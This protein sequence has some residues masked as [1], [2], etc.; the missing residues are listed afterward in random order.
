MARFIK[1]VLT[2]ILLLGVAAGLLLWYIAP[3]EQLDLTYEEVDIELKISEVLQKRRLEVQLDWNEVN[4]LAKRELVH[5]VEAGKLPIEIEGA[6]LSFDQREMK[7]KING[8][9]KGIS[10]EGTTTFIPAIEGKKIRL[11]H[12]STAIK[13][14]PIPQ[15][16][17]QLAPL[18]IAVDEYVP[19]PAQV[20]DIKLQAEGVVISLSIAGLKLR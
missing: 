19:S 12:D 15:A 9:W 16:W 20:D 3:D 8:Q 5:V 17:V 10:F 14:I 1:I 6:D 2:L 7:A 4:Q 13:D 11:T 18:V